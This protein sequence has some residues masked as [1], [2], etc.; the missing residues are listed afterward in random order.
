MYIVLYC[1]QYMYYTCICTVHNM[2]VTP[3]YERRG[4]YQTRLK[5]STVSCTQPRLAQGWAGGLTPPD[6]REYGGRRVTRR[7]APTPG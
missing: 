2:Y 1:T 7:R 6:I 4:I 5:P 3:A